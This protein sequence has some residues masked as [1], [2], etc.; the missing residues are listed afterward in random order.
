MQLERVGAVSVG[1][2]PLQIL[3]QVDDHDGV[4]WAF[5]QACTIFQHPHLGAEALGS[6][7]PERLRLARA[8]QADARPDLCCLKHQDCALYAREVHVDTQPV[9]GGADTRIGDGR[10][11]SHRYHTRCRA[12][13]RSMPSW[14]W[15]TLLCIAFLHLSNYTSVSVMCFSCTGSNFGGINIYISSSDK[16]QQPSPWMP[17]LSS[18]LDSSSCTLV[19]ISLACICRGAPMH[20]KGSHRWAICTAVQAERPMRQICMCSMLAACRALNREWRSSGAHVQATEARCAP[21]CADDC[22]SGEHFVVLFVPLFCFRSHSSV[23]YARR[24]SAGRILYAQETFHSSE[25]DPK[26]TR[27][28]VPSLAS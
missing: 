24:R 12:P 16:R 25:L 22:D 23:C 26:C 18:P 27:D 28:S 4:E 20:F 3:G 15:E 10:L 1:C 11:P 9:F 8:D 7:A 21:V 13:L 19:G 5:L 2:L 6:A 17:H 14:S